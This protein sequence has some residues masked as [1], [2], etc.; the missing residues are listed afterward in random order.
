MSHLRIR[1][2][3][4][5]VASGFNLKETKTPQDFDRWMY[6]ETNTDNLK[7]LTEKKYFQDVLVAVEHFW[8]TLAIV[9]IGQV[10]LQI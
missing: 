3:A 9:K 8:P 7:T 1:K 2:S 4:A 10:R 5:S 6:Y